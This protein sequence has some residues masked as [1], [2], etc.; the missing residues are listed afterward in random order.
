MGIDD[1][2]HARTTSYAATLKEVDW[3]GALFT[4]KQ[5]AFT[6]QAQLESNWCWA[7]TSNG[8]SHF[9][10]FH[11][12]WTQC[13]IVNAELGRTDACSTPAPA[14]ANVPWYLDKALTRTNNFVSINAGT[15]T[16]AQIRAEID[17]GRPMG[18]RI[19]W[20]GGGGHFMVIYGY[21]VWG[22]HQYV[23]I[24]D[25]IYG[26]ST[27]TLQEF[28]TNYQG[29]GSWT[30]YYITKSYWKRWWPDFMIPDY[31]I[32]KVWEARQVLLLK[33][34]VDPER[35]MAS[36]QQDDAQF[37]LAHRVYALGLDQLLSSRSREPAPV[38][39]RVYETK[40]G[41]P[42]AFYDVDD[43]NEG[44]VRSMSNSAAHLEAVT[45]AIDAAKRVIKEGDESTEA[46]MLRVPALN[47][48]ALWVEGDDG[49]VVVPLQGIAGL[50]AGHT[51]PL[52]AALSALRRA[53]KPLSDMDDT[54]GA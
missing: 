34:A 42:V 28:S 15:A 12:T 18:A 2:V 7:A 21:S 5:L 47:F 37:G 48:E 4:S 11:S 40:D 49:S 29:S 51:Y 35:L 46:R 20:S 8:V 31:V 44:S 50:D 43:E 45:N 53:A 33:G 9:Y 14:A 6:M 25:P 32:K 3:W 27:I 41:K 26:K 23:D 16:F 52:D 38:G 10:W 54:M 19:G 36:E 22:A 30:H 24:D 39:L 1:I 13:K 17:A